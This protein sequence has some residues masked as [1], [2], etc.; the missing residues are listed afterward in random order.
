MTDPSDLASRLLTTSPGA[1]RAVLAE[2]SETELRFVER[3]V[4]RARLEEE[5]AYQDSP[6]MQGLRSSRKTP[7]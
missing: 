7:P 1:L 6:L 4:A 5:M 3:L 2:C